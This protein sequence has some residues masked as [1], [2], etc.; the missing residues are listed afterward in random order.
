MNTENVNVGAESTSMHNMSSAE[1]SQMVMI[2][3]DSSFDRQQFP[4]GYKDINQQ[5]IDLRR[6]NSW[7]LTL[8]DVSTPELAEVFAINSMAPFILCSKLKPMFLAK[9]PPIGM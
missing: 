8:P 5:Q 2:P 7:L 6:S 4:E 3:E 1:K 9:R